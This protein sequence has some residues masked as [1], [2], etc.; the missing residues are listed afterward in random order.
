VEVTPVAE[1]G[2][3]IDESVRHEPSRTVATVTCTGVISE[4]SRDPLQEVVRRLLDSGARVLRF[5]LRGA[6][7]DSRGTALV[8]E[9]YDECLTA[10]TRVEALTPPATREVFSRLGLP[11]RFRFDGPHVVR[12]IPPCD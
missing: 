9:L 2:L 5:D 10:G 11:L 4:P 3:K 8:L 6:W 12:V 1:G 7:I